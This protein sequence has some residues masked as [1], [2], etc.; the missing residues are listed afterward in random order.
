MATTVLITGANRGIG[1]G[2][3]TAYLARPGHT[4]IAAVRNPSSAEPLARLSVAQGS[5][6]VVVKLDATIE[7]DAADAVGQLSAQHAI[8]HV[9]IVIANAG[10]VYT[11]PSVADVKIDDMMASLAP[12][13]FGAIWLYQATRHLLNNAGS[14]KWVTIGSTAGSIGVLLLF[15]CLPC[16][17]VNS[18]CVCRANSRIPTR[19]TA[20]PRR[21]CTGSRSA[22]IR[23]RTRLRRLLFIRAGWLRT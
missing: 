1:K 4:V 3:V 2:L 22:S 9:D 13:V 20:R 14:P 16:R 7:T 11:W 10:V 5:R 8:G 21:P 12:N 19:R 18:V 6:L 17:R 15:F 23:K